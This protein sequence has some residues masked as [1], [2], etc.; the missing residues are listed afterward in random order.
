MRYF[1]HP[2]EFSTYTSA[3]RQCDLCGRSRPGYQGPFYGRQTIDFICEECL[4]SGS[5]AAAGAKTN[6][7]DTSA[8]RRQ[9]ENLYAD[10]GSGQIQEL[11]RRYTDELERRTPAPVTWQDFSWPAHCGDYCTFVREVGRPDLDALAPDGNGAGF[12]AFHLR[13][14]EQRSTDVPAVWGAIRPDSPAD[15]STAY[16]VGVYLFRCPHCEE[17]VILWDAD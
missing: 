13:E 7:G 11:I 12:F 1:Q 16:T 15:S 5:L 3:P 9:L 6:E 14:Q 4:V 17:Y 10:K 8:L 2:H